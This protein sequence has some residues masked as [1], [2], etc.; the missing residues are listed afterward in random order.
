M[1][2]YKNAIKVRIPPN[3]EKFSEQVANEPRVVPWPVVYENVMISQIL[4][5][6]PKP[7]FYVFNIETDANKLR[8][9]FSNI[10]TILRKIMLIS[11]CT[12]NND[13]LRIPKW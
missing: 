13:T 5:G 8:L 6:F 10:V 1:F 9:D 12:L 4:P 3:F 11:I 2:S 7:I